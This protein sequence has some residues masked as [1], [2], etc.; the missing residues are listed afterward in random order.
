[1]AGVIGGSEIAPGLSSLTREMVA[2]GRE[3]VSSWLDRVGWQL[4]YIIQLLSSTLYWMMKRVTIFFPTKLFALFAT[5]LTV[6][7]SATTL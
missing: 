2:A 3:H 7:M 4:S 1:M 6:T 5:R